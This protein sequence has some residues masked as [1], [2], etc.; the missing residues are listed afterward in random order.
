MKF[1]Q[2]TKSRVNSLE[3]SFFLGQSCVRVWGDYKSSSNRKGPNFVG[4]NW[5][6][7]YLS[8]QGRAALR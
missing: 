5:I 3:I 1:I 4:K 7:L 2:Q 6:D 8:K